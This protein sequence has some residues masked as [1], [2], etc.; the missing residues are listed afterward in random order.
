MKHGLIVVIVVLSGC[1]SLTPTDRVAS[2]LAERE[3]V[4]GVSLAD[5]YASRFPLA[6][7]VV[8]GLVPELALDI[9]L[10]CCLRLVSVANESRARLLGGEESQWQSPDIGS[11]ADSSHA[12]PWSW[13]PTYTPVWPLVSGSGVA[14]VLHADYDRSKAALGGGDGARWCEVGGGVWG[15][16]GGLRSFSPVMGGMSDEEVAVRRF[17]EESFGGSGRGLLTDCLRI[18]AGAGYDREFLVEI[19]WLTKTWVPRR[20]ENTKPVSY[21]RSIGMMALGDA[22]VWREVGQFC[23]RLRSLAGSA[24]ELLRDDD[25]QSFQQLVRIKVL[26]LA[27]ERACRAAADASQSPDKHLLN[28]VDRD[29]CSVLLAGMTQSSQGRGGLR[30]LPIFGGVVVRDGVGCIA[31]SWRP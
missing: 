31:F 26:C 6:E 13:D 21:A 9:A 5:A 4:S 18:M 28:E 11:L 17:V 12:Q 19:V 27:L 7:D 20:S 29:S 22:E 15:R 16:G 30:G 23:E 1:V 3:R 10:D 24:R 14:R 2:D 25:T 8:I